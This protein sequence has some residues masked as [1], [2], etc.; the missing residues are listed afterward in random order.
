MSLEA[1][2]NRVVTSYLC[3]SCES[4]REVHEGIQMSLKAAYNRVV[5]SYLCVSCEGPSEVQ[6]ARVQGQPPVYPARGGD[7]CPAAERQ[8][9]VGGGQWEGGCV[10]Q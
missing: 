2:Y 4:P 1:A 3:V 9:V 10:L 8:V 5:T 7:H 6:L